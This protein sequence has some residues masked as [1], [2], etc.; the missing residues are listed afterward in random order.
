MLIV[1]ET[2]AGRHDFFPDGHDAH[3]APFKIACLRFRSYSILQNLIQK[4]LIPGRT[5]DYI[6]SGVP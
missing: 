6:C 5:P 2:T 4:G 1:G 3:H